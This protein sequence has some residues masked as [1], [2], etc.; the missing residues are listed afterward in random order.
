[1]TIPKESLFTNLNL[2]AAFNYLDLNK[3]G[4]ICLNDIQEVLNLKSDD[5]NI[6][7]ELKNEFPNN[8]YKINFDEFKTLMISYAQEDMFNSIMR[9]SVNN[10]DFSNSNYYYTNDIIDENSFENSLDN[11]IG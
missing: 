9:K 7:N 10:D 6:I 11:S 5:E 3:K 2:F 4:F 1:M 8:K